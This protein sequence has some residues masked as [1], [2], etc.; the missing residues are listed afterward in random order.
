M[1][2]WMVAGEYR[3]F[4]IDVKSREM[5]FVS[6]QSL[7][8]LAFLSFACFSTNFRVDYRT[9]RYRII[10]AGQA[11]EIE[12]LSASNI[13]FTSPSCFTTLFSNNFVHC[14]SV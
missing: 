4:L 7:R 1:S 3:V 10:V 11:V 8:L 6:V 2:W 13:Y 12:L 9:N 14:S 5:Y